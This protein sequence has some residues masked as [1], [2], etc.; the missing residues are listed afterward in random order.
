[1]CGCSNPA[2]GV[3]MK[4]LSQCEHGAWEGC[5]DRIPLGNVNDLIAVMKVSRIPLNPEIA[6]KIW[7]R[8]F[9]NLRLPNFNEFA[10]AIQTSQR[11]Q[12]IYPAMTAQAPIQTGLQINPQLRNGLWSMGFDARSNVSPCKGQVVNIGGRLVCSESETAKEIRRIGSVTL[13][14]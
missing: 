3:G 5:L 12:T 6:Q 9:P 1:M 14:K 4:T 2:P 10:A 11:T 13:V 7:S 8:L